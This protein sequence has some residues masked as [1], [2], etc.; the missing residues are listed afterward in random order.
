[1]KG[2]V[3]KC[4]LCKQK[5]SQVEEESLCPA[6]QKLVNEIDDYH[7]LRKEH[8]WMEK[9]FGSR[10]NNFLIVFSL[11]VTAGFA[12][13]VRF[14]Q[15]LLFYFGAIFLSIYWQTALLRAYH[16]YDTA[17]MLL[18]TQKKFGKDENPLFAIEQV[19]KQRKCYKYGLRKKAVSKW[20]S[21]WIPL[22]CIIFILIL[23]LAVT[24]YSKIET[25]FPC[26]V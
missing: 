6:C 8:Q 25:L 16:K 17:C 5:F 19:Q 10:V 22:M 9:L 15:L 20:L 24:F 21:I 4:Q 12:T 11:I 23:A 14:L 18:L 2:I 7:S 13:D 26:V 1:M 3:K